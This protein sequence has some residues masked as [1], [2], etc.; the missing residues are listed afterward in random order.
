VRIRLNSSTKR[1]GAQDANGPLFGDV[2]G[3]EVL[4]DSRIQQAMPWQ[5]AITR[6]G[7]GPLRH[8]GLNLSGDEWPELLYPAP[9]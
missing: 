3:R 5:I 1:A 9:R 4:L 2:Q 6:R 7:I 8:L